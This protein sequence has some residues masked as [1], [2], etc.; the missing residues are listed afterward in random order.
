M[1]SKELVEG[2]NVQAATHLAF[3]L[4]AVSDEMLNVL[5]VQKA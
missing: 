5:G 4:L 1:P 3:D 2:H